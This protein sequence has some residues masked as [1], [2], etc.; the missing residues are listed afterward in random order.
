MKKYIRADFLTP[1]ITLI[2]MV[3]YC[4]E[5]LRLSPPIVKGVVQESF[6]PV[7]ICVFGIP[8]SISLV[9]DALKKISAAVEDG[10]VGKEG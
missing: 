6:F 9:V 10:G 5:A 3:I 1:L 2:G 4:I 7:I 8:T